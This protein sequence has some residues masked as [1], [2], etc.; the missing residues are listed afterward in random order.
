M[1][2][3]TYWSILDSPSHTIKSNIICL[4]ITLFFGLIWLLTKKFKNDK[5]DGDKTILLW[6]IGVFVVLGLIFYFLLTY[7][8]KDT[9]EV[10]ILKMLDSKTTPKV[11]GV[12]SNFQRNYRNRKEIIEIF[13]VDSVQ[14]AYGDAVLGKFNSFS[15]TN[16]N[17]IFDGQI[18]RITYRSGSRYGDNFNSIL[19]LEI[20]K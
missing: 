16:N 7:V 9:S 14:F 5:G 17:V 12:I 19:K 20:I 1:K 11:E 6:G 3:S 10:Q 13:R 8:Y 15:Q 18:V 4:I 2:Y